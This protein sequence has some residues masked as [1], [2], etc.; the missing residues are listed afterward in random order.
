MKLSVIISSVFALGLVSPHVFA[1]VNVAQG[2]LTGNI[3]ILSSYNFRGMTNN[4]ENKNAAVQGGLEYSHKSGAYVGYWASTL[5]YNAKDETA[6]DNSLENNIYGGYVY[7]INDDLSVNVGGTYYLYYPSKND[8]VFE[9]FIGVDYKDFSLYAHTLTKD[10][11]WGNKGD[12]YVVASYSYPLKYDFSLNTSVAGS[13][14]K[15]KGTF[16]DSSKEDIV[17][18]HA[19]VGL[20]R[21]IANTGVTWGLDYIIGGH[22]RDGEKQKNKMVLGLSYDF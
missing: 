18:R 9:P 2:E 5:G 10:V 15:N 20:S 22:D 7:S 8:N 12:T 14:F 17:F 16:I 4:P 6:S 19:T 1:G 13:Y 3:S 21:E 11:E